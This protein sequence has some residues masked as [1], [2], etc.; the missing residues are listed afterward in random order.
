[1]LA[2]KKNSGYSFSD[3][4]AV[5]VLR[6]ESAWLFWSAEEY[7][8]RYYLRDDS[9]MI[10]NTSTRLSFLKYASRIFYASR[11]PYSY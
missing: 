9:M 7:I 1:M 3:I 8:F 10:H 11:L 4:M 6:N 2:E 5:S